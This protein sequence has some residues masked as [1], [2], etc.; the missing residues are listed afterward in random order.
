MPRAV[1]EQPFPDGERASLLDLDPELAA[2]LGREGAERL[3][4]SALMAVLRLPAGQ[5]DP[6]DVGRPPHGTVALGVLEGLLL[7]ETSEPGGAAI[8][9][10]GDLVEP[11]DMRPELRWTAC[12]PLRMAV[13]DR[14]LLSAL[15]PW[16]ELLARLLGHALAQ[17]SRR[18]EALA[19]TGRRERGLRPAE[20]GG[21][22]RDEDREAMIAAFARATHAHVN[23]V[24]TC[25]AVAGR[26]AA[27]ARTHRGRPADDR[28]A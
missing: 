26:L 24:M 18:L 14:P 20:P 5:V 2:L 12:S 25:R 3:G 11:W 6:S 10:P 27:S 22:E 13:L 4:H 16:P 17:E 7:R 19:I 9:G 15:Q 8:S 1:T 23:A 28:S 21:R